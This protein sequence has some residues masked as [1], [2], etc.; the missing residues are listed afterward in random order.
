MSRA[1]PKTLRGILDYHPTLHPASLVA[2][3]ARPARPAVIRHGPHYLH[4]PTHVARC[5]IAP[6]FP[7]HLH[8]ALIF[9]IISDIPVLSSPQIA[10]RNSTSTP[11]Q[12]GY[13]QH[14]HIQSLLSLRLSSALSIPSPSSN[15][16]LPGSWTIQVSPESLLL[17]LT[18]R[19]HLSVSCGALYWSHCILSLAINCLSSPLYHH[20]LLYHM[21]I[22]RRT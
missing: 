8:R 20:C 21:D 19:R 13:E 2:N 14:L 10:P 17:I 5:A 4:T 15:G 9:L 11:P 18:R 16:G 1:H 22:I 6:F 7:E 3:T 12:S